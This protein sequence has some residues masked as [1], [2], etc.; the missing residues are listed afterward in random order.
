MTHLLAPL[1]PTC[2]REGMARMWDLCFSCCVVLPVATVVYGLLS[3]L[4]QIC[5]YA[6]RRYPC[7]KCNK[8]ALRFLFRKSFWHRD[9]SVFQCDS[10]HYEFSSEDEMLP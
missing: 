7:P 1:E 5:Y 8:K 4:A 6:F 9:L 10:C 2:Y 3:L